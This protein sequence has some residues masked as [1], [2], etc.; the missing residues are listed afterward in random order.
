MFTILPALAAGVLVDIDK[1]DKGLKKGDY[2]Q[3]ARHRRAPGAP[4]AT[5]HVRTYY[6]SSG[7]AALWGTDNY[8]YDVCMTLQQTAN[9]N[10]GPWRHNA[11]ARR[12]APSAIV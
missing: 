3:R 11:Y 4:G 8:N 9:E 6:T 10:A 1:G 5:A 7:R 2:W 12:W